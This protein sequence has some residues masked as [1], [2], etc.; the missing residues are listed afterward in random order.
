M[1]GRISLKSGDSY[2]TLDFLSQGWM[3]ADLVQ[4][5]QDVLEA[6]DRAAA[7]LKLLG[8]TLRVGPRKPS[9]KDEHWVIVDLDGRVVESNSDLLRKAVEQ[10]QPA[11]G[12][13]YSQP[14]LRRIHQVLD[15]FNFTVRLFR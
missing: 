6:K 12:D 14:A 1:G 11:P 13:P 2:Y 4:Y 15:Q 5:L 3:A 7:I 10:T 9:R 8:F